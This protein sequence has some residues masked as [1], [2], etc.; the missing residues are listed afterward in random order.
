MREEQLDN[1]LL[2][3]FT[4]VDTHV[5]GADTTEEYWATLRWLLTQTD[6][7]LFVFDAHNKND[8][9]KQLG[10]LIAQHQPDKYRILL[11]KADSGIVIRKC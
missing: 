5:D 6:L 3:Q 9:G 11:N 1:D 10:K 4:I 8:V 7:A 2:K